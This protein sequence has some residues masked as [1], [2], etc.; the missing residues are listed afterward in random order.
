MAHRKNAEERNRASFGILESGRLAVGTGSDLRRC[1]LLGRFLLR[2]TA[3][4]SSQIEIDRSDFERHLLVF[5]CHAYRLELEQA[6]LTTERINF[7]APS[8]G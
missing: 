3:I 7:D 8:E 6:Q 1:F 4:L 2:R 5:G